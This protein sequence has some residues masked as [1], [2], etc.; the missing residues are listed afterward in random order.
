MIL[1]ENRLDRVARI[2]PRLSDKIERILVYQSQQ[3]FDQSAKEYRKAPFFGKLRRV[4]AWDLFSTLNWLYAEQEEDG[5][6]RNVFLFNLCLED[7][8]VALREKL[9]CVYAQDRRDVEGEGHRCFVY[10]TFDRMKLG[11]G[12]AFG[13]HVV[14]TDLDREDFLL[15]ER[16]ALLCQMLGVGLS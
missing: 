16:N 10:T 2:V 4:D 5:R 11:L 7:E 8:R 13:T 6:P 1:I 9:V 15:Y 14:E 12:D 3:E